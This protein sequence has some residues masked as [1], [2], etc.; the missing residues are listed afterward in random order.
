MV[1]GCGMVFKLT[2]PQPGQTAWKE[3]VLHSFQGPDGAFPQGGVIKDAAGNIYGTASGGGQYGDGLAFR[4]TPPLP[5]ETR[6]RQT[7]LHQF[8]ISTS[9]DTPVG[10][11]V[12][13][14]AGHLYGVAYSGGQGLVGTVFEIVP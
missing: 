12:P 6:W 1:I 14:S 7:V 13:D 4:L 5:G 10:E 3:T 9:G 11:L 2:P 8:D